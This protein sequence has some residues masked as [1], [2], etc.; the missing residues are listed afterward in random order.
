MTPLILTGGTLPLQL[1]PD[2]VTNQAALFTRLQAIFNTFAQFQRQVAAC[3]NTNQANS[4]PTAGRPTSAN[5]AALPNAGV[6]YMIFDTTLG[7]PA[8]WN[9]T[10]WVNASGSTV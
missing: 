2:D 10:H 9:G 3:I 1:S 8:W 4:C 7:I 5:L 6:G